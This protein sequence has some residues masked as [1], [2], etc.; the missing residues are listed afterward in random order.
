MEKIKEVF[1]HTY[2]HDLCS[3]IFAIA[4]ADLVLPL[5]RLPDDGHRK[6]GGVVVAP[7][8]ALDEVGRHRTIFVCLPC[9]KWKICK[10]DES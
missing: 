4:I 9:Q 2:I 1:Q 8:R 5:Q 10:S 7:F 6:H 3:R